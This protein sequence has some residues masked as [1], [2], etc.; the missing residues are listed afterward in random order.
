[1]NLKIY[2]WPIFAIGF[3]FYWK[4][5]AMAY[6]RHRPEFLWNVQFKTRTLWGMIFK[7]ATGRIR[8][9]DWQEDER[10]KGALTRYVRENLRRNEVLDFVSRDFSEYTWSLRTLD[11][12][13]QY[14]GITYTDRTVQVDEVE[15]AVKQEMQGPG[16]LLG[17]RWIL[18]SL[19]SLNI[20]ATERLLGTNLLGLPR[21]VHG[22]DKAADGPGFLSY[23][24]SFFFICFRAGPS[25][26]TSAMLEAPVNSINR[27]WITF[28]DGSCFIDGHEGPC[29]P[30]ST[31]QHIVSGIP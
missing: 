30:A 10:L 7:M 28:S 27:T 2:P 6:R 15:D 12:R 4:K 16:R 31:S 14:F 17:Y 29:S 21:L 19:P 20:S 23:V 3:F 26:P 8:N 18:I 5:R 22:S 25:S 1:M 24:L 9:N 11:R 13:L